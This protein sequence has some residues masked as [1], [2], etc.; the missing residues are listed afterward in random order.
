MCLL[1]IITKLICVNC[2][3]LHNQGHLIILQVISEDW[4]VFQRAGNCSRLQ[5]PCTTVISSHRST[6]FYTW[7]Q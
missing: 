5:V 7:P 6:Q 1:N 3:N 4:Q 2:F